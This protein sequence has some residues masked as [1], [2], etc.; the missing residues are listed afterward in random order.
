MNR[1]GAAR[2]SFRSGT[3]TRARA[4]RPPVQVEQDHQ[5]VRVRFPQLPALGAQGGQG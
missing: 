2:S 5:A 3:V 1:L 4:S